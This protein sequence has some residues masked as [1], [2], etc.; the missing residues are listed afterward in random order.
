LGCPQ[1]ENYGKYFHFFI[2]CCLNVF[3]EGKKCGK[4]KKKILL[5]HLLTEISVYPP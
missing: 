2:I 5:P 4:M 1:T 3:S